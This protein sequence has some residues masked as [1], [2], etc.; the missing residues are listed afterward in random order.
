MI[1]MDVRGCRA[2][3]TSAVQQQQQ[4]QQQH[5][6][7]NIEHDGDHY[8]TDRQVDVSQIIAVVM[9]YNEVALLRYDLT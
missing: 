6:C 2:D 7:N 3:M 1:Y 8:E 4:Q 9:F 5:L